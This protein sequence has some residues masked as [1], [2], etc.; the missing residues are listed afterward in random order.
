MAAQS[1]DHGADGDPRG[2]GAAARLPQAGED[3]GGGQCG[4]QA[5][6]A[7]QNRELPGHSDREE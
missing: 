1:D 4:E 2:A 5:N 7:R 3:T 6:A